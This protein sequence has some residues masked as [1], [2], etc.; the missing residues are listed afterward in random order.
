MYVKIFQRNT[1]YDKYMTER[2]Y[3]RNTIYDKW[4]Q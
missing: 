2:V 4:F 1:T 3:K